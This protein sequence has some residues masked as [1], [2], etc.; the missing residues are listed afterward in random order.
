[1]SA[2]NVILVSVLL[3]SKALSLCGFSVSSS[4]RQVK[5]NILILNVLSIILKTSSLPAY[6]I[7]FNIIHTHIYSYI[8]NYI[9][10]IGQEGITSPP[11]ADNSLVNITSVSYNL[12]LFG[13]YLVILSDLTD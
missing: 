2:A 10:Y 4:L 1:M 6:Q 11:T 5:I 9:I 12:I 13:F 7:I 3:H 8:Y